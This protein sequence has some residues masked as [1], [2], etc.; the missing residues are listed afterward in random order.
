MS[1]RECFLRITKDGSTLAPSRENTIQLKKQRWRSVQSSL[2]N[3]DLWIF[4]IPIRY[5]LHPSFQHYVCI[6]PFRIVSCNFVSGSIVCA[7]CIHDLLPDCCCPPFERPLQHCALEVKLLCMYCFTPMNVFGP[8]TPYTVNPLQIWGTL[9]H[10][11][12]FNGSNF[13]KLR[14]IK[15][16]TRT[17]KSLR[18]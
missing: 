8:Y 7:Q 14:L 16:T 6:Q 1:K 5:D 10:F 3:K 11:K 12:K 15:C 4:K 17:F 9:Q 2:E 18:F 13:M